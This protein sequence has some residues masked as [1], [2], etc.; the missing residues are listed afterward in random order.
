MHFTS[1]SP[2]SKYRKTVENP[3]L[4]FVHECQMVLS[5]NILSF[6]SRKMVDPLGGFYGRIDGLGKLHEDTDKAVI[7]NTR[8]L[9]TYSAAYQVTGNPKHKLMADRA[10]EYISTKFIDTKH[11]GV[12]WMVDRQGGLVNGK[13]QTYAQAFAVYALAEY[14][15]INEYKRA[16]D[17]AIRIFELMEEHAFDPLHDGYLEALNQD[18]QP[19]RDVRLS[20]KDMNAEKTMNNHLHVLEAYTNLY[21]IWPDAKLKGQLI[22]LIKLMCSKLIDEQGHFKLFFDREWNLLSNEI[23]FGHDI[24]GSWLLYEAAEV[25]DD[26]EL[27]EAVKPIAI[28]MI[29]AAL[30]GQ[31][32]D[33][34]LMNEANP[35]GIVDD[36][37]HWW[38]QAEAL[39]GLV[40]AWQLTGDEQYLDKMNAV[41]KFIRTYI[42]DKDGEWHWKVNKHGDVDYQEDKAGPW[43]CPYHNGRAM[44]EL[45]NRLK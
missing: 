38:P 43:K 1:T 30:E 42:M 21:R 15:K 9:W 36:D 14:H 2:M 45:M 39:V 25:V 5:E 20:D 17:H 23:S 11:G 34:G 16:K 8:I 26:P 10:Y 41:W 37:K 27:I 31:D 33:G 3:H 44:I 24:E 40:N 28:K 19:I 32:A 6:W 18:W 29:Q 35:E 13:K 4:S 12:V 7:L 22:R